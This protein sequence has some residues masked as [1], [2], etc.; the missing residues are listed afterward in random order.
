MV[1]VGLDDV[2]EVVTLVNGA[3]DV[4]LE[5]DVADGGGSGL[6]VFGVVDDEDRTLVLSE[7]EADGTHVE[8][9]IVP[10]EFLQEATGGV[11]STAFGLNPVFETGDD[12]A[13][14]P[15]MVLVEEN[16]PKDVAVAVEGDKML[17]LVTAENTAAAE[18]DVGLA[19]GNSDLFGSMYLDLMP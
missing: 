1:S 4:Y 11:V 15:V 17:L 18:L 6:W 7:F 13:D 8:D 16:L 2:E 14:T 3:G 9:Y 12:G 10:F 19:V 5:A